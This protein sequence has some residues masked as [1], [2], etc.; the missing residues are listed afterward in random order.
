MAVFRL[1]ALVTDIV[2]SI[3]GTTF[4]RQGSSLVMMRKS[5]GASRGSTQQNKRIANNKQIFSSWRN[6]TEAD[7]TA[8]NVNAAATKVKNKFGQDVHIS[9]VAFQRRCELAGQV[10]FYSNID[11]T[12][13]TT[14]INAYTQ[15]DVTIDWSSRDLKL[16]YNAPDGAIAVG[17]MLEYSQNQL[18]SPQFT[19]RGVI[20]IFEADG[21]SS[22]TISLNSIPG[23]DFLNSNYKLRV[24]IYT[25]NPTGWTSTQ[26]F[27]NVIIAT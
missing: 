22:F 12:T 27:K 6:L 13:F 19:R 14:D 9:G 17:V 5:N 18:N 10:F 20:E 21:D 1:G 8:W 3:G 24:Y 11:P 2:G 23:L 15:N 16:F 7:Q 25:C 4:K 26:Q